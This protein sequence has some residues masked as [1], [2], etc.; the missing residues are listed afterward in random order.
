M[1]LESGQTCVDVAIVN[2]RLEIANLPHDIE[3]QT[4]RAFEFKHFVFY[5]QR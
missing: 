1:N 4:R 5:L 2:F 3:Q